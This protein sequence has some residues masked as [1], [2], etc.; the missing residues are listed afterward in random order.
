MSGVQTCASSDLWRVYLMPCGPVQRCAGRST[1]EVAFFQILS[2]TVDRQ[3][4]VQGKSVDLGVRRIIIKKKLQLDVQLVWVQ[5]GY[6]H[7][8]A[9]YYVLAYVR[10]VIKYL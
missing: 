9:R 6:R 10:V 5:Q 3:S 7:D 2:H 1:R 8:I 4:V